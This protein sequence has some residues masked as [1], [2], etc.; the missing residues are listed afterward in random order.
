MWN[1]IA[2][3][4][5]LHGV[6]LD[7]AQQYA[8]S[9]IAAFRKQLEIK[10]LDPMA[11]AS[12]GATLGEARRW[13]EAVTELEKAIALAPG[14]ARLYVNLGRAELNL[15]RVEKAQAAFDKALESAASPVVWN[16]IAYEL[17]VHGVNLDRAQP[18]AESAI[19]ATAAELRNA[20]LEHITPRDLDRIAFLART[21]DTLGWVC[22]QRGDRKRAERFVEAAW[23]LDFSG[24]AGDHLAQIYEK[25]GKEPEAARMYALALAT[26]HPPAETRQRLE[27]LAGGAKQADALVARLSDELPLLREYD[28]P[29]PLPSGDVKA[30]EFFVLFSAD[31]R[32]EAVKFIRGDAELRGASENIRALNFGR[33]FPDE[34][35]AKLVR[36]GR[37]GCGATRTNCTFTLMPASQVHSVE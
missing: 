28:V 1:T 9:A 33:M 26:A 3:E 17:S 13:P 14:D 16:T 37:L 10:P 4:L 30:A 31:G 25:Q 36:R 24:E 8:E 29:R 35:P 20:T 7:R 15:G 2:H 12:L 22:F 27:K 5:S 23:R 11:Q 19:T 18:Y 32:P 21:W 6:N 34:M